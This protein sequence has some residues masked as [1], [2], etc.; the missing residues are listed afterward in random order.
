MKIDCLCLREPSEKH[1]ESQ[2][3]PVAAELPE[4]EPIPESY[5]LCRQCRQ[6]ITTEE[7]RT[8]VHGAH[9]HTFANPSGVVFEIG[10][11]KTAVG[12][13]Y[14]GHASKEFTWFAGFNWRI[15]VCSMCL[16][17]LG[18]FFESISG[19]RFHGLILDRLA[20]SDSP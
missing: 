2:S 15:A 3:I 14:S 19:T 7:Q 1:P 17:H 8:V 18:W 4:V 5:I 13:G 20:R 10:C 16:T 9:Q 12:C 6:V 11:F